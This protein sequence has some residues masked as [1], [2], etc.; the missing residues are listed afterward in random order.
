MDWR[1][2]QIK[3]LKQTIE[4]Q[5]VIIEALRAEIVVLKAA[6][7]QRDERIAELE[8]RLGLNSNNSGKP[9]S[10][11]GLKKQVRIQNLREKSGKKCGGQVGHQGSTLAQVEN[12]DSIEHHQTTNCPHCN[13]DLTNAPVIDVCKKQVF[14]I[15]EVVKPIVTEHQFEVKRC[16]CC[17]KRV[18]TQKSETFK[19]PVQYG[20]RTKAV[21]SYLNIHNLIPVNR[22][23]QI[24][25][26]VFGAP[27]SEATVENTVKGCSTNVEPIVNQ[28]KEYF[29]TVAVKG[30]DESG[31]RIDGKTLWAHTLSNDN[32]THYRASE[33]RGDIPNDLEGIVV[34]DHFVSYY[35][36]MEKAQHALCNAHHLRELKAI[37]EID[38][39][40]WARDMARLLLFGHNFVQQKPQDITPEWLARYRRLYIKII[41]KG[42]VFHENLGILKKPQ[43]GKIKRR[44][45]HNLLLRLQ[46][47]ADDVLRFLHDQNV[48]FTNNQ[49]E[50]ALRMI[51]VKQK[52]SGCFRTKKGATDFLTVRSY[53]ATAQKQGYGVLD[54]LFNAIRGTPINFVPT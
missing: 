20:P 32:F 13:T 45:G 22:V 26:S 4:E 54:A 2:E 46:G 47:R 17:R 11:D 15:P 48:P 12:P 44:P 35:A 19:A 24:M 3:L 10:S 28:I 5:R 49:S 33:K 25:E 6:I 21:I 1:D 18:K 50:Q 27:V 42:L 36:K 51:K 9:P 37:E 53:T 14:D 39:E 52:V 8:R 31:F 29:K 30:A 41:C 16:P 7:V 43:R 34:H 40:P 38:K 23:V